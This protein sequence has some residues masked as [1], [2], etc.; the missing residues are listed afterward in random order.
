[1]TTEPKTDTIII[2]DLVNRFDLGEPL[3]EH[4]IQECFVTIK[5]FDNKQHDYGSDNIARGVNLFGEISVVIRQNDKMERLINLISSGEAAANES[6]E[7]TLL[8]LAVYSLM[9]RMVR[10][11]VWPG[12]ENYKRRKLVVMED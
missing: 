9:L 2:K 1:M 6:I 10:A 4:F 5:T 8:D 12:C 7:D 3:T 11:R